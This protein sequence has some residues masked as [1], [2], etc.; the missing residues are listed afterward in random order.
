MQNQLDPIGI[1][2]I[3]AVAIIGVSIPT[4]KRLKQDREIPFSK[5][6]D[7]VI[8]RPKQLEAYLKRKEAENVR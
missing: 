6:R 7:R 5:V 1:G 3:D 2:I 4:L 8:S